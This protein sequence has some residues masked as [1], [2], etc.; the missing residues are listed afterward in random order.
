MNKICS[1]LHPLATICSLHAVHVSTRLRYGIAASSL[2]AGRIQNGSVVV[3]V[4]DKRSS[5]LGSINAVGRW[6]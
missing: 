1:V 3:K 2:K 6:S 4:S 5:M